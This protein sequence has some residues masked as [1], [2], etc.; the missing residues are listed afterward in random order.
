MTEI[1]YIYNIFVL[2]VGP[3][4]IRICFEVLKGPED[5]GKNLKPHLVTVETM[6]DKAVAVYMTAVQAF[7]YTQRSPVELENSTKNIRVITLH[8]PICGRKNMGHSP[9]IVKARR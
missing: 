4:Q 1:V 7:L 3:D 2:I 5:S 9:F 8:E 6:K